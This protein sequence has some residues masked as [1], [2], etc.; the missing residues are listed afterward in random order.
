VQAGYNEYLLARA[1]RAVAK[2]AASNRRQ[3]EGARL[4]AE[5]QRRWRE[6]PTIDDIRSGVT[7]NALVSDL[8]DA[9][10]PPSRWRFVAV[11]LPG[12]FSLEALVFRFAASP[13]FRL[14]AGSGP[15]VVAINR[16]RV[17]ERWP[18]ALRRPEFVDEQVA[19]RHALDGALEGCAKGKPLRA[20]DVESLRD[21]LRALREK[22]DRLTP[23]SGPERKQVDTFL[24]LLDEATRVFLDHAFSEELIRDVALHRAKT[25]AQLLGFMKKYRLLFDEADDDPAVWRTYETLYDLLKKQKTALD[26]ADAAPKPAEPEQARPESR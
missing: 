24:G 3:E 2:R 16:M 18:L 13:R 14:P 10:I 19:Y 5:T 20:A 11:D 7:L 21:A 23:P 1:Q 8:A 15:S 9:K 4:L 22:S 6:N 26:L 12:D 17:G 25:V